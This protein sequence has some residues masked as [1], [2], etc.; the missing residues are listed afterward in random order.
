MSQPN[1][2]VLFAREQILRRTHELVRDLQAAFGDEP[3]LLVCVVE[4]AR[5][6]ARLVQQGLAGRLPVHEVRAKS[7]QGTESTGEVAITPVGES[8]RHSPAARSC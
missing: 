1:F 7:Y 8:G 5:P 6:F 4:G 3:P 2:P